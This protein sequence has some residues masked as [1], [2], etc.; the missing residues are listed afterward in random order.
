ME[1]S[2]NVLLPTVETTLL[3]LLG[4]STPWGGRSTLLIINQWWRCR[5]KTLT[6]RPVRSVRPPPSS[7]CCSWWRRLGPFPP[8]C[9]R[10]FLFSKFRWFRSVLIHSVELSPNSCNQ[11]PR[12]PAN[13]RGCHWLKLNKL[14][15]D[16]SAGLR[17][18]SRE[19]TSCTCL[20]SNKNRQMVGLKLEKPP[21]STF[22]WL[23]KS[24]YKSD[25]YTQT[26]VRCENKTT[27]YCKLYF[28]LSAPL[29]CKRELPR[30]S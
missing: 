6:R 20:I 13:I 11:R 1:A 24:Q 3:F 17:F 5:L 4:K 15:C 8:I 18:M 27:K 7:S 12:P 22:I 28:V 29:Q 19:R 26:I 25:R 9:S 21:L 23:N 10:T 2:T 30:S 16:W 14:L